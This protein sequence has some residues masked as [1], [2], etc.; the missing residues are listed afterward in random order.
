MTPTGAVRSL[1]ERE[2]ALFAE[3]KA[4]RPDI[5]QTFWKDGV[6][7]EARYRAS[8][9]PTLLL[10]KEPNTGSDPKGNWDMRAGIQS[11][12]KHA[13]TWNNVSRWSQG[14]AALPN[15]LPYDAVAEQTEETRTESVARLAVVNVKKVPGSAVAVNK[16]I[17]LFARE[18]A[19]YLRAQLALYQPRLTICCG[20]AWYLPDL[21]SQEELGIWQ[22]AATGVR[23]RQSSVI[24][25]IIWYKHPQSRGQRA[26][27]LYENLVATVSEI[28]S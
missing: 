20:S 14:I 8:K 2:D 22:H 19:T 15:E 12:I 11:G 18:H 1:A 4:A 13:Q 25:A 23:W 9:I 5:A 7:D 26:Q 16:D 10:L 21:Y 6:A 3:W 17:H 28:L 24:G 27:K